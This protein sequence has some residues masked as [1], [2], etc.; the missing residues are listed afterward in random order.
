MEAASIPDRHT[1]AR[2][3]MLAEFRIYRL[4]PQHGFNSDFPIADL[5]SIELCLLFEG[6]GGTQPQILKIG[7]SP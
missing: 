6:V 5:R 1:P 3:Q 7:A 2:R 4:R